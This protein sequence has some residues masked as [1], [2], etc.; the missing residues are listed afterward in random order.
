MADASL[1]YKRVTQMGNHIHND[2]PNYRR[3]VEMVQSGKLGKISRVHV[4]EDGWR[5]RRWRRTAPAPVRCGR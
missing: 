4:L 5:R 1:Q 2:F 3:V